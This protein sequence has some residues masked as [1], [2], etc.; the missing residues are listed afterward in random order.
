MD[1]I[2]FAK[3]FKIFLETV[4]DCP[5]LLLF[6]DHLTHITIPVIT[7]ALEENITILKFP[8]H[9]TNLLQ[10]WEKACF[11]SLK[12]KWETVLGERMTTFGS[13]LALSKGEFLNLLCFIWNKG[14]A[15][16]NIKSGFSTTGIWPLNK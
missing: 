13:K 3:W 4:K 1:S 14:M 9:C 15:G 6:D 2:V 5:L 16:L 7:G 10:P 12:Q 8:L 11:G